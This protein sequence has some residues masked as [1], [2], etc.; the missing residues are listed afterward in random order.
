[1][2]RDRG[3]RPF[4]SLV[5][6]GLSQ[7]SNWKF[8]IFRGKK[9]VSDDL[10]IVWPRYEKTCLCGERRSRSVSACT[11]FDES[12]RRVLTSLLSRHYKM[13]LLTIPRKDGAHAQHIFDCY[14]LHMPWRYLFAWYDA[15]KD[16][17]V[18]LRGI[19]TLSREITLSKLLLPPPE[20]GSTLKGKNLLPITLKG[21]TLLLFE[22]TPFEKGV[23]M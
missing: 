9:N 3:W 15:P 21:K 10:M 5:R 20:K 16:Y 8:N 23:G 11:K 14:Y 7:I 1:M 19:D 13:Y 4:I 18:H 12:I 22:W 6:S 2:I 17:R